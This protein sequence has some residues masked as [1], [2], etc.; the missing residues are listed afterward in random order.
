MKM[1]EERKKP[2]MGKADQKTMDNATKNEPQ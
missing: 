2:E 1:K